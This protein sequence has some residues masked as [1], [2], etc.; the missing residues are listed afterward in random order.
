MRSFSSR[1]GLL[2][3]DL[4]TDTH[5]GQMMGRPQG[6]DGHISMKA[7]T[8]GDASLGHRMPTIARKHQKL[9]EAR[10]GALE[11]VSEGAWPS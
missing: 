1:V 8:W 2:R 11:Q 3:G 7:E 4:D 6:G 9:G 10:N 5:N